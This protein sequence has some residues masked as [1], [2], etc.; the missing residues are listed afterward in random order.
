VR[1]QYIDAW[2][3]DGHDPVEFLR[4]NLQTEIK[5]S[6]DLPGSLMNISIIQRFELK[7]NSIMSLNI[8]DGINTKNQK[9]SVLWTTTVEKKGLMDFEGVKVWLEEAHTYTSDFFKKML[10]PEF[11]ASLDR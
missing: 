7:G 3:L 9:K 6:Y 5:T 1:L 10:K 8:S 4:E 2:E 11:Y